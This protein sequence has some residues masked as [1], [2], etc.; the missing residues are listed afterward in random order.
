M[1]TVFGVN[2]RP[3]LADPDAVAV[4]ADM[5][6][7]P[8]VGDEQPVAARLDHAVEDRMI[9]QPAV[10]ISPA[11]SRSTMSTTLTDCAGVMLKTTT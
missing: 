1:L 4:D 10:E 8:V 9:P 5:P 3:G 6:H 7:H 11:N 2:H